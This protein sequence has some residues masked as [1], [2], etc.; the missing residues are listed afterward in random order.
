MGSPS[1]LAVSAAPTYGSDMPPS[2]SDNQLIVPHIWF[3]TQAVEAAE[4]YVSVFPDSEINTV[5]RIRNTPSGDCDLVGFS[6]GGFQFQGISAG[7]A[8]SINPSISFIVNFDPSRDPA[9][10]E[11]LDALWQ[12]LSD[13]GEIRM[14]LGSYPFSQ[15]YGWIKDRYGVEWQLILSDASGDERP[16]IVPALMF[17]GND[18][19]NA[20]SAIGF[21]TSV[22]EHSRTGRLARWGD[23]GPADLADAVMF[24]DFSLS[25]EWFA[26]MDSPADH[27]FKFNEAV[28]LMVM[29][30]TQEEVD[31]YWAKLTDGGVEVQC[32]W[33]KDRYGVSWQ[34]VPRLMI[35][36]L[37]E[38]TSDQ[39]D[40]VTEAFLKMVKFDIA[41]LQAAFDGTAGVD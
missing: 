7:P 12:K 10:R 11:S 39:V 27:G 18:F 15:R 29:C 3:D 31:S 37:S 38:G 16:L 26:A 32:G 33:L 4:F 34:V 30:D 24:A 6:L 2:A 41:Q 19:G 20:E 21:Y 28:S 17:T 23:S 5:G 14:A 40:R 8:F 36:A 25:G 9:A 35:H 13:G 1:G 22:F